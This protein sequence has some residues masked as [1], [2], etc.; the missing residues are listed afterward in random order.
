VSR[1]LIGIVKMGSN[2]HSQCFLD[3]AKALASAL[4]ALGHEVEYATEEAQRLRPGR[5]ILFGANNIQDV[6]GSFPKDAIIFNTEQVASIAD[7]RYFMQNFDGFTSHVVWDYSRANQ[8]VLKEHGMQ[9]VVHCPIGYIGTMT[10]IFNVQNPDIDVLYYGSVNARRRKILDELDRTGMRIERLFGIYGDER[11]AVIA[12][13]KVIVN[14]HYYDHAVFEIFR[15]SHLLA[16]RKCVVTEGG[17]RDTEL[18]DFARKA[19]CYVPYD[20]VVANCKW[21]VENEPDRK[22][23]EDAGFREFKKIDFIKSVKNALEQS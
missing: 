18:E 15:V 22:A 1:F 11:D 21:L 13:S 16:N 5:L 14:L 3:V 20:D 6:D 10:S 9:H 12:R 4:R 19:T 23:I 7:P 8:K 17:L 2:V